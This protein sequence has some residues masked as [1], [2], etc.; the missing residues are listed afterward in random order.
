MTVEIVKESVIARGQGGGREK[1]KEQRGV[2]GQGTTSCGRTVKGV[3]HYTFVRTH[4]V[5]TTKT[6]AS[7]SRGL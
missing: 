7:V 3:C 1:W 6:E 5:S 4:G 2:L